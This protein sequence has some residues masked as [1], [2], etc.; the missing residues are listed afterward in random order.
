MKQK[1]I[2]LAVFGS[3]LLGLTFIAPPSSAQQTPGPTYWGSARITNGTIFIDPQR[4]APVT[5]LTV[6]SAAN[7]AATLTL[8]ASAGNF[9]YITSLVAT[10]TCTTAIVGTALLGYTS[11]NLPGSLA[12]TAGNACA[13]GSTSQDI[14]NDFAQPLKSSV[15]NTDTT[16]VAPAA[17]TAGQIR[18]TAFYFLAS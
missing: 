8:P 15:V 18:L 5:A 14:W 3:L 4:F 2:G 1:L 12:W 6:L 9:H 16:I 7:T 11:T 13:V 17:G 10:R